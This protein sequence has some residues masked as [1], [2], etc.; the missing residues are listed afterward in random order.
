MRHQY[1]SRKVGD[2][3]YIW[4]VKKLLQ[5]TEDLPVTDVPLS[6][7]RELDEEYWFEAEGSKPPTCR[8]IAE[9]FKLM[10]DASLDYPIILSA[11]GRIMD[12]MHRVCK[13]LALGLETIKAVQ[14]KQNPE[15]NYINKS[16]SDLPYDDDV[17]VL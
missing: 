15:P 1:H 6:E 2:D 4:D 12:G 7:I 5:L 8:N 16:L 17:G 10:D 11:D 9:H 14:F 3:Q 13:A